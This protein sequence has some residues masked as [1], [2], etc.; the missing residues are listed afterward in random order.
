MTDAAGVAA[1]API[2]FAE[3]TGAR[4]SVQRHRCRLL[5]ATPT[6]RRPRRRR[7]SRRWSSA[8]RRRR[9]TTS[10]TPARR[11]RRSSCEQTGAANPFNGIDVGDPAASPTLRRP[12]RRRRSRRGR[13]RASTAPALLQE[14]RHGDRAGL[15]A[16]R[17]APP[18]RS[19]ASMSAYSARRPSPT[20][21]ATAT[22]TWSSGNTTARCTISRTPARRPRRPSPSRPAPPIPST[23]SMSGH[24]QRADLRRPRRRRRSRR[25]R[26]G[27]DGTLHYFREHRHGDRAGLRASRPAPPIRSTASMSA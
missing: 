19:T 7:R 8:A 17:P 15:H 3:Q 12:R 26:R 1:I 18:I 9:P 20:S 14:H 25:G 13:R 24:C 10:R 11:S 21:T 22:S 27:N 5:H 6:L 2:A 23:A 16:S 4:Q